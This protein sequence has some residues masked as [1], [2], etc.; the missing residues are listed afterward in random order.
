MTLNSTMFIFTSPQKL[1]STPAILDALFMCHTRKMLRLVTIGE[2]HLY[3]QHGSTFCD[4]LRLLGRLIFYIIFKIS[5]WHPLF[6]EMTATMT[7]FC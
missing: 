1:A 2:A 6:L 3:A 7:N 4:E 5:S